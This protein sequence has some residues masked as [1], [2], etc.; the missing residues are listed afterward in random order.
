MLEHRR[1][2]AAAEDH[3]VAHRRAAEEAGREGRRDGRAEVLEVR[4]V[5]RDRAA[6]VDHRDARHREEAAGRR[7]AYHHAAALRGAHRR[8][9]EVHVDRRAA[10]VDRRAGRQSD[11]GRD[12]RQ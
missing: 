8:A 2:V 3:R 10:A 9:A 5:D 7:D 1:V 6:A 11:R 4:R 12:R